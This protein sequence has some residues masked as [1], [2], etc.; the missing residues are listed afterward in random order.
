MLI[1]CEWT[2]VGIIAIVL[3]YDTIGQMNEV[4]SLL[5]LFNICNTNAVL[6]R[7]CSGAHDVGSAIPN[8]C[9]YATW[10]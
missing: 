10:S 2:D 4:G 6:G 3:T 7:Y 5:L 9:Y 1:V 8:I